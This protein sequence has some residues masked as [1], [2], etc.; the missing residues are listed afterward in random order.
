MGVIIIDEDVTV[1][2]D[3]CDDPQVPEVLEDMLRGNPAFAIEV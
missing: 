3:L 2:D 1:C